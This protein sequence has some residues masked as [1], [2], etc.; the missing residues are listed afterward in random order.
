MDI[1][2]KLNQC[3][4]AKNNKDMYTEEYLK[5]KEDVNNFKKNVNNFKDKYNGNKQQK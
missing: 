5:I 4:K 1:F 2:I 3:E